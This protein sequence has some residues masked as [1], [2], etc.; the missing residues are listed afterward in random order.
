MNK[1]V[2]V[3]VGIGPGIGSALVRRFA[4]DGY[5]GAML[6]RNLE[7]TTS[8]AGLASPIFLPRFRPRPVRPEIQ[9]EIPVCPAIRT[10]AVGS[11]G[12]REACHESR[13]MA[14]ILHS[15]APS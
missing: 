11:V 8:L 9:S 14:I 3:V 1:P 12:F 4:A 7:H 15:A 6:T 2:W 10:A 13:R 5:A